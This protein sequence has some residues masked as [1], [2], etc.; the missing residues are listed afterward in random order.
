MTTAKADQNYINH[1]AL[2]LDASSSMCGHAKR[3]VEVADEQ[4]AY[5][6]Q[7]SK[8]LDQETRITVYTF[9][10]TVQCV[11]YDKDVLRLPSIAKYY[12][13]HGMTALIDATDLALDDLAMTPEKY[14]D[15]SFLVFVLTDGYE[16][17]SKGRGRTPR[18]A[19]A[20]SSLI[21]PSIGSGQLSVD[22]ANRLAKLPDHWTLGVF[23]PDQ[24]G[25]EYARELGFP[26]DNIATWNTTSRQ[27]VEEAVSV[28]RTAT[29][30]YMT[31]RAQ[32]IRGSKTLFT[33]GQ[34]DAASIKAAGLKPLPSDKR[35]IIPVTKTADAFEKVVKPVT[36][37]RK[38]AETAWFVEIE[39]FVTVAHPPFRVGKAYYQLVKS[40]TIQGDK[41][42]AVLEKATN[43]VYTG[44][45]AR[46][47]LGLPDT[48]T[49]VKPD[50]NKDYEIFVQSSSVNR[51][52]PLHTKLLLLTS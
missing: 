23:V 34:V 9:A 17:A 25:A 39:K 26:A 5:L 20:R 24:R 50:Q 46:H 15:H 16:N 11:V 45:A 7:R 30:T 3:L 27:G 44:D 28:M 35:V 41:Q 19:P 18:T 37:T 29:D 6:A 33:G 13:P 38:E 51:H 49:R 42:V 31:N 10:D 48:N 40:E 12:R 22:L 52:L 32:G 47:L 8:E 4:I 36:K 21:A 43:K 14:G 1:I 2:V